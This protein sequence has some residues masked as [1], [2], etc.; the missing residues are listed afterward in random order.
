[1]EQIG[2]RDGGR[3]GKSEVK[4][5]GIEAAGCDNVQPFSTLDPRR[6]TRST[7]CATLGAGTVATGPSTQPRTRNKVRF[8]IG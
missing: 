3:V 6:P 1:M 8:L 7:I 5:S 2:E 4:G